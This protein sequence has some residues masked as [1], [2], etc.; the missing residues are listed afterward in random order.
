MSEFE[1]TDRKDL[2]ITP[3]YNERENIERFIEALFSSFPACDLLIIDD[4]SPD[5]TADVVRKLSR[6]D[7]RIYLVEREGKLGLGSAYRKG[8]KWALEKHYERIYEMDADLSHDPCYLS[9]FA[10]ELE[11]GYDIV[12]GSRRVRGGDVEGWGPIRH[13]ISWGGSVYSRFVLSI[14]IKDMTTGYK[15]FRRR[16]LET[17]SW[18]NFLSEGFFF[19]VETNYRALKAGFKIKEIPII[20]KDRMA[21]KSKM[22]LKIFLE[23]FY[24]TLKL[25]FRKY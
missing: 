23:A 21:G 15:G 8:F 17:L 3:T 4:S 13:F 22:S 7:D 24:L 12:L 19:Q 20:F 1:K 10:E 2:I 18:E 11:K 6:Q 25:R 14:S 5:R 16:V 9:A